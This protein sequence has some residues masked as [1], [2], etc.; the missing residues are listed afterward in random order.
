MKRFVYNEKYAKLLVLM[1]GKTSH[2]DELAKDIKA[3]SGH[4]RTVLEQW[5]KEKIISKDQPGREYVIE[6][7]K[8][9]SLIARK[10]AE[11]MELVDH[12]QEEAEPTIVVLK[13]EEIKPVTPPTEPTGGETDGKQ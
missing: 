9:G 1:E 8:K 5:H 2:I 4:L 12:Y 13:D 10:F 6:L 7:T 11:V 3:N